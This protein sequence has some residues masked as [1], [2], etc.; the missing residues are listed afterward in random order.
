[1]QVVGFDEK[2]VD[3]LVG[4]YKRKPEDSQRM[5]ERISDRQQVYLKQAKSRAFTTE[6]L[7][8]TFDI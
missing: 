8:R 6:T 5:K 1:M 2:S 4:R 7:N 3:C